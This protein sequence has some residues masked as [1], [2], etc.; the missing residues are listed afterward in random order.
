MVVSGDM[1]PQDPEQAR[2]FAAELLPHES[3]LRAWLRSRFGPA[4]EIDDIVQEAFMRVLHE[5]SRRVL[6][7]PKAFLF[8]TARNLA[9]D[10]LRR[11]TT[12]RTEPLVENE[13]LAV[14]EGGEGIPETLARHQDLA[15]LT[16][17]IQSLPERCRQVF[18]L[19]KVYGL[20]QREIADRLGISE[21]TV[22]A[23]LTIGFNKCADYVAQRRE[24][25][26]GLP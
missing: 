6:L 26:K 8:T 25:R 24:D 1:P 14:L 16:E 20:S 17:A 15:L 12:N 11:R 13:D 10:Q 5:R 4:T 9:I 2:W 3:K 22:S 7:S 21:H 19:C 23:Q 18:T